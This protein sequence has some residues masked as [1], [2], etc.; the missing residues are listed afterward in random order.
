METCEILKMINNDQVKDFLRNAAKSTD[1]KIDDMFVAFII[2][3]F[4]VYVKIRCGD[5]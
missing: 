4:E 2:M 1:N 3:A 5:E